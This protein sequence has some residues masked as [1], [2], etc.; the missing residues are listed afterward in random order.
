MDAEQLT[1]AITS[2]AQRVSDG[3]TL[4]IKPVVPGGPILGV[5]VEL[6]QDADPTEYDCYS[7]TDVDTF[8]AGEWRFVGVRATVEFRGLSVESSGIWGVEQGRTEGNV[9]TEY[10]ADVIAGEFGELFATL[11]DLGESLPE[12]E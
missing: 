8:R 11:R 10:L 2:L 7:Q 6:D 4:R 5:R 1:E 9:E 3:S 12:S